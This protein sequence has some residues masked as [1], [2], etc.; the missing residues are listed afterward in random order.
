MSKQGE[1]TQEEREEVRTPEE[2]RENKGRIGS[3]EPTR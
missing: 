2:M 1:R 3:R